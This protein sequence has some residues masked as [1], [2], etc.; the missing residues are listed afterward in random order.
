MSEDFI[1][2]AI[3]DPLD[4]KAREQRHCYKIKDFNPFFEV[5]TYSLVSY[6]VLLSI[7]VVT[8]FVLIYINYRVIKIVGTKDFALVLMLFFLKLSLLCYAIFFGF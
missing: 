4:F 7:C 2:T 5:N 1:E 3:E 6:Q 8:I